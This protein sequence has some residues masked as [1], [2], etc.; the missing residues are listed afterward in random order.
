MLK[1]TCLKRE[2]S[3]KPCCRCLWGMGGVGRGQATN[4]KQAK[5]EVL[6]AALED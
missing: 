5:K 2:E 6:P 4:K 1:Y 3:Q